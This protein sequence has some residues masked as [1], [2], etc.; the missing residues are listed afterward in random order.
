MLLNCLPG[1]RRVP[2]EALCPPPV[3]GGAV[4][5]RAVAVEGRREGDGG[6]CALLRR[7][8]G[9]ADAGGAVQAARV[10]GAEVRGGGRLRPVM[11]GLE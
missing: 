1:G 5:E 6:G 4:V 10:G 11:V 7:C 8:P 3:R 9:L 2:G